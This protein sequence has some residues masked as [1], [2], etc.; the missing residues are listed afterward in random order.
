MEGQFVRK[1]AQGELVGPD[2]SRDVGAVRDIYQK[3]GEDVAVGRM[4][5]IVGG[6]P[7]EIEPLELEIDALMGGGRPLDDDEGRIGTGRTFPAADRRKKQEPVWQ[8]SDAHAATYK[9]E[10]RAR[11]RGLVSHVAWVEN[12]LTIGRASLLWLEAG[13]RPAPASDP[14][15]QTNG[16]NPSDT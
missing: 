7:A 8:T 12:A 14:C 5:R 3:R 13:P 11:Y 10:R 2:R 4:R 15:G 6:I 9:N 16:V 1:R